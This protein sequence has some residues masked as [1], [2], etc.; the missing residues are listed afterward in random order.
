MNNKDYEKFTKEEK[1]ELPNKL[2]DAYKDLKKY[3]SLNFNE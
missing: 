2:F 3:S 1:R